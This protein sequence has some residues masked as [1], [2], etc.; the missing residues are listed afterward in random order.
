[1]S[2]YV[3]ADPE[4][5]FKYIEDFCKKFNTT[6]DDIL[7]I[8]GDA[9]INYDKGAGDYYTKKNLSKLPITFFCIHGNHEMR[10]ETL[11]TYREE[12]WMGGTV[13]LEEEVAIYNKTSDITKATLNKKVEDKNR[14]SY[15]DLVKK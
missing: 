6:T 10:P 7:I 4:G 1:M 2:V 13:Y 15:F 8:L 5:N 14:V 12:P 9:G 3:T 11:I